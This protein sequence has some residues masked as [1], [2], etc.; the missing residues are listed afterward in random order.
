MKKLSVKEL[1]SIKGGD[2]WDC[3]MQCVEDAQRC[4]QSGALG[5]DEVFAGCMSGCWQQ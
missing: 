2:W 5:C 3:Y 4:W 1:K